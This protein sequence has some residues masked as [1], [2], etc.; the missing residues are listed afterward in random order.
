VSNTSV[1]GMKKYCSDRA[2]TTSRAAA[3]SIQLDSV[4]LSHVKED[5]YSNGNN[6][7]INRGSHDEGQ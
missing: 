3:P 1:G 7:A 6:T 4:S 5:G 2:L